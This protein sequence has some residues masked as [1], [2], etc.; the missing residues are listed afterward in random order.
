ML[1]ERL[2]AANYIKKQTKK[3]I[4]FVITFWL[5]INNMLHQI[6]I[7]SGHLAELGSDSH[8]AFRDL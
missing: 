7:Y 2:V 6:L 4:H 1:C 5:D 8:P 3:L